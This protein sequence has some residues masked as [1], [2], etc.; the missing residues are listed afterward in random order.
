[1]IN[2]VPP[3][4][5]WIVCDADTKEWIYYAQGDALTDEGIDT[6]DEYKVIVQLPGCVRG[7]KRGVANVHGFS[8]AIGI[9]YDYSAPV[10]SGRNRFVPVASPARDLYGSV[11]K[12]VQR[13]SNA[14]VRIVERWSPEFKKDLQTQREYLSKIL[15]VGG[16]ACHTFPVAN[17]GIQGA[18]AVHKDKRDIRNTLWAS[19][20]TGGITFPAYRHCLILGAGD[21]LCF[22][23]KDHWHASMSFPCAVNEIPHLPSELQHSVIALY[24]QSQQDSYLRNEYNRNNLDAQLDADGNVAEPG[25]A[26]HDDDVLRNLSAYELERLARIARNRREVESRGGIVSV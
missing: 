7:S 11:L 14:V 5:L 8:G 18:Y 3:G 21:V 24:Y 19:L 12:S 1:M 10:G 4:E 9:R 6:E 15:P 26:L 17:V 22:N 25:D 23:G 20:K 16:T 2:K 13:V